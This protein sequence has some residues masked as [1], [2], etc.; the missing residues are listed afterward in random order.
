MDP[1]V[2]PFVLSLERLHNDIFD[3]VEPLTDREVNRAHPRL[4]N[5]IGIL[6]RHTAGSERHWII[7][8]V[9]GR[10][11]PRNR[12]AE[13]GHEPLSKE[14]LVADLRAAYTEVRAVLE[15]L[16]AEDLT[17]E[18]EV[19]SRGERHKL[20]AGFALLH[21]LQHTSYHLGQIQLFKRLASA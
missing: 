16:R 10:K 1:Q 14:A 11:V 21:S 5:T 8:V 7:E 15:S 13:F 3:A 4:S 20:P 18:I 12:D 2:R 9:G 6:L 19:Q 17:R